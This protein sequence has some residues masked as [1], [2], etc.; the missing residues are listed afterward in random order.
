M[1]IERRNQFRRGLVVDVPERRQGAPGAGLHRH[2]G[3]T[4]RRP[5]VA[6][7]RLARAEREKLEWLLP[8]L[9][10]PHHLIE[11]VHGETPVEGQHEGAVDVAS[12][13]SV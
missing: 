4:E 9:E 11:P 5:I 12:E 7:R 2:A 3:Q 6:G 13:L 8:R 10:Q 1:P